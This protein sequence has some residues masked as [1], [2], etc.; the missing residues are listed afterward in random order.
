MA[1][2]KDLILIVILMAVVTYIPRVLP[3]QIDQKHIPQWIKNSLE[4]LPVAIV[5]AITLPIILV[6]GYNT[7]FISAEFITTIFALVVAYFSKNLIITI[8]LALVCFFILENYIL[9]IIY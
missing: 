1:E 4:F 2:E 5:S 8:F 7:S 3:L 9:K 6:D